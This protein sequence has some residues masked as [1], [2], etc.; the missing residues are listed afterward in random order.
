MKNLFNRNS[1]HPQIKVLYFKKTTELI[2]NILVESQKIINHDKNKLFITAGGNTTYPLLKKMKHIRI[3]WKSLNLALTDERIKTFRS[4][5]LNETKIKKIFSKKIFNFF[6]LKTSDNKKWINNKKLWPASL[7]WLGVGID[8][9][10]ASLFSNKDIKKKNV[11]NYIETKSPNFPINRNSLTLNKLLE[12]KNIFIIITGRDK[13][14]VLPNLLKKNT[15]LKNFIS[16][17]YNIK[18]FISP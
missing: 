1:I 16:C 8:G 18:L 7:V 6:S 11:Y 3:N 10:L 13:I 4:L 5:D 2:K 9:H 17:T 12:S 15:V 14:K